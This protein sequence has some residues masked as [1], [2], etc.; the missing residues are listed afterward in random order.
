MFKFK[1]RQFEEK[2]NV[3]HK[4]T[5]TTDWVVVLVSFFWVVVCRMHNH[6]LLNIST[7]CVYC[8]NY[9]LHFCFVPFQMFFI[10]N[11]REYVMHTQTSYRAV[12]RVTDSIVVSYW[13]TLWSVVIWSFFVRSTLWPSKLLFLLRGVLYIY[14]LVRLATIELW[15]EP[16]TLHWTSE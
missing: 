12:S 16:S 2:K 10:I 6:G 13:G 5:F 11:R 8:V 7:P 3:S 15:C 1:L 4:V 9:F 14:T